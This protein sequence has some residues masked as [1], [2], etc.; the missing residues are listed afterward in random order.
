MNIVVLSGVVATEPEARS[1]A[2]GS[3]RWSFDLATES[4]TVHGGAERIVVPVVWAGDALPAGVE[5][6]VPAVVIGRVRRRFFRAGGAT[7]S[8]TEVAAL[9]LVA[10]TRRR[11]IAAAL[12]RAAGALGG[13]ERTTLRSCTA[14]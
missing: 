1:L 12:G 14:G 3:C 4:P 11:P 10:V 2:D 13:E 8:R 9:E 7:V 6:A 5:A